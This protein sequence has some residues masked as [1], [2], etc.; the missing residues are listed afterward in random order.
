MSGPD[1]APDPPSE[2]LTQEAIA[3]AALTIL[4]AE[5][6]DALSFRRLALALGVSHTTVHRHCGSLEGLLDLC[7]DQ[8]TT[9][10]PDL[11]PDL[12]WADSTERRFTAL[13]QLLNA[14]PALVAL[15]RDRPWL[16]EQALRRLVEPSLQANLKAG[17]SPE[18][19]IRVYRQLYLFTMGCSVFVDH[20]EAPEAARRVRTAIAGLDRDEFP[21]LTHD[22]ELIVTGV[23]DHAVFHEGLSNL[24]AAA[25]AQV[26]VR[27]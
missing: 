16:G 3:T 2:S 8:L 18:Q 17:F 7:V 20:S 13:Y 21:A 25:Q 11:S 5:G 14:H 10:L 4:D 1:L 26:A 15:R 27:T 23:S 12:A 24:I 9:Q 19:S 6:P 22:V